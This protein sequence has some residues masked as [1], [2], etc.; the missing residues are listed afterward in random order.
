MITNVSHVKPYHTDV[1][2]VRL[3]SVQNLTIA[4]CCQTSSVMASYRSDHR[5]LDAQM[6]SQHDTRNSTTESAV[7][8]SAATAAGLP[9]AK[10]RALLEEAVESV[11][12][13]FAK[14]AR[15]YGRGGLKVIYLYGPGQI[16]RL[17]QFVDGKFTEWSTRGLVILRRQ[18]VKIWHKIGFGY[19]F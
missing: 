9:S 6:S 15:G 13:T 7:S 10:N 1:F 8:P 17:N 4:G 2:I 14:H 12:N 5:P 16:R 18:S 3:C 11:V 19:S